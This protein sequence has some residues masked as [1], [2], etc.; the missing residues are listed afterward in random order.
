MVFLNL[1]VCQRHKD[2]KF[3]EMFCFSYAEIVFVK[4]FDTGFLNVLH[5]PADETLLLWAF[6]VI[7][8]SKRKMRQGTALTL[9]SVPPFYQINNFCLQ[10]GKCPSMVGTTLFDRVLFIFPRHVC[11]PYLVR[12]WSE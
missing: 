5:H 3:P 7:L 2:V 8:P 1:I 9:S 10:R 11:F 12:G 4:R 6:P